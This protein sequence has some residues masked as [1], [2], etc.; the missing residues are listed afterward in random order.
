MTKKKRNIVEWAMHYRQIV[1]MVACC[2]VLGV[3][4]LADM[5]KNEFPD[6]TVRQGVVVAVYPACRHRTLR[7]SSQSRSKTTYSHIRK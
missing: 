7:N 4:G 2:L 1:I 6:F 5:N 3:Y